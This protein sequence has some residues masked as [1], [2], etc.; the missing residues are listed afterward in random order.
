MNNPNHPFILR[1]TSRGVLLAQLGGRH[2]AHAVDVVDFLVG[3]Y[4]P[5][6]TALTAG[7]AVETRN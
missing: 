5:D 3:S 2:L 1:V 4:V 7:S 6:E